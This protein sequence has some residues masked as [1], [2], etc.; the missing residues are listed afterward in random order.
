MTSKRKG[1]SIGSDVHALSVEG[2]QPQIY[3]RGEG[4]RDAALISLGVWGPHRHC[5]PVLVLCI[6]SI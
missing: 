3:L 5:L 2:A 6:L 4:F 1:M